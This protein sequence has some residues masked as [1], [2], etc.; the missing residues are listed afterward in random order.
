MPDTQRTNITNMLRHTQHTIVMN[1]FIKTHNTHNSIKDKFLRYT[2]HNN[3][4]ECKYTSDK[5]IEVKKI[6]LN[7]INFQPNLLWGL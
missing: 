5:V 6:F 1:R 2:A 7:Y 3:L 4:T